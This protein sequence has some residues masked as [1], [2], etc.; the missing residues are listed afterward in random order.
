MI[1]MIYYLEHC[2]DMS[3]IQIMEM[4]IFFCSYVFTTGGVRLDDSLDK[5]YCD[6]H[7]HNHEC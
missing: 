6:N 5:F 4:L 3:M 2:E 1:M 7:Y